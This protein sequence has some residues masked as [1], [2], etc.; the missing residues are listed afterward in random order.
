MPLKTYLPDGDIDISV[1]QSRGLSLRTTWAAKLLA[2][3]EEEARS[4][5]ANFDVR[6]AQIIQAEV[7]WPFDLVSYPP[8]VLRTA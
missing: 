6:D 5:N 2:A 4:P 3:L 1:F 7:W 8:A